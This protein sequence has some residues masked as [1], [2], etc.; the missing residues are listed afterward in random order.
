MFMLFSVYEHIC[1]YWV[2]VPFMHSVYLQKI[3][4]YLLIRNTS[5]ISAYFKLYTCE[6]ECVVYL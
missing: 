3:Y 4:T 1:L 5:L 6:Y 2:W